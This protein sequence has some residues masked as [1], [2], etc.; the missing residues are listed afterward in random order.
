MQF[1]T[2]ADAHNAQEELEQRVADRTATLAK[3][4]QRLRHE[5]KERKQADE[6]IRKEHQYLQY[7][8]DL[9]DRD[10]KLISCE[11]HDGLVQQ[12]AGAIMRFET[13]QLDTGLRMLRECMREARWL[14][15]GCGH[16]SLMSMAWWSPLRTSF[17]KAMM[18]TSMIEFSHRV[19]FD[20]LPPSL[21]NAIF[22]IVQKVST[23]PVV[24]VRP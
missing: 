7:L 2:V 5:I 20:R 18:K 10:R 1:P 9:Q 14:I 6:T 3:T 17:P 12:L 16:R 24:I 13:G 19:S 22:R 21:E 8:L 4:N 23:M 15:Q 11:L